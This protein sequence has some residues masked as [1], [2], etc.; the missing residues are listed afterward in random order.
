MA[1]YSGFSTVNP[2]SQKNFRLTDYELIKQDLLNSINTRRGT[3]LMQPKEGCDIWELL[4]EPLTQDVQQQ[5]TDNFTYIVNS[6][7]RV[8]LMEIN[9]TALEDQNYLMVEVNLNYVATNQV[10]NLKILFDIQNSQA[11][12]I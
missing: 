3:R 2:L 1:I 11:T 12:V 9:I 5:I 4:Y 10:E 8:R 7:P 6:D